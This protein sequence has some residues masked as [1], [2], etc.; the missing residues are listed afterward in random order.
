MAAHWYIEYDA[1][2]VA[3]LMFDKNDADTNVLS[4]EVLE[5]LDI[6]LEHLEKHLPKAL[7]I[8]SAKK[9]SIP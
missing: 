9:R 7:V 5:Q 4:V 3:W 8:R 1:H 6:Q 2:D